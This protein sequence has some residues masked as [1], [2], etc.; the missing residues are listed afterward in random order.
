MF[1]ASFNKCKT[2]DREWWGI[3]PLFIHHLT[4]SCDRS[5]STASLQ[6]PNKHIYEQNK[7]IEFVQEGLKLNEI[8]VRNHSSTV[9]Q[10]KWPFG[11]S[12][13][14]Q[15]CNWRFVYDGHYCTWPCP[16]AAPTLSFSTIT[17]TF[18]RI[19]HQII[20]GESEWLSVK[21]KI[22]RGDANWTFSESI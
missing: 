4:Q 11:D 17:L 13:L 8:F 7:E 10:R 16:L 22:K 19:H 14:R 9:R 2:T 20:K 3:V 1:S 6:P 15:A 5:E 18:D 12:F 21:K